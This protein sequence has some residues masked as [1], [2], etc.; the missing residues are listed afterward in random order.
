MK[1]F[2]PYIAIIG[3]GTFAGNMINI[4]LSYGLHWTSLD[5]IVFMATFAVDFPLL[6]GPTVATLLPAFIATAA[7]YFLSEQGSKSRRY[8]LY[9]LIGLLIIN[10]QTVVYHLPLNLAF[11]DQRVDPANVGTRLMT[12]LIF[13]WIRVIMAI[14][15]GYFAIRGLESSPKSIEM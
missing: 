3:I 13:H 11:M 7:M 1:Q 8:W 2:L 5:P 14:L 10:I 6:L 4:G 15:A 9:A 12:W